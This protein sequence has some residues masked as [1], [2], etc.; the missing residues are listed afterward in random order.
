MVARLPPSGD[1]GGVVVSGSLPL[2]LLDTAVDRN[3]AVDSFSFSVE[4]PRER[5]GG[6]GLGQGVVS[7]ME[8]VTG[9][10]TDAGLAVFI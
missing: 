1:P 3:I 2:T 10:G 6:I 7:C 8:D 5:A 9:K 4:E